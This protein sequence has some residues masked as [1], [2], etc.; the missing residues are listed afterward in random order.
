MGV[1]YWGPGPVGPKGPTGATGPEGPTGATGPEG[2]TGATGPTGPTGPEGPAG[3][4]GPTGATGPPGTTLYSGL[5]GRPFIVITPD[6]PTDGGDYGPNT[7]GTKTFGLYEALSSLT[8]GGTI[9]IADGTYSWD[10]TDASGQPFIAYPHTIIV[11]GSGVVVNY[12]SGTQAT[13][14]NIGSDGS[15]NAYTLN[16]IYIYGNGAVINSSSSGSSGRIFNL[17]NATPTGQTNILIDGFEID[18]GPSNPFGISNGVTN[19]TDIT[20]IIHNLS[21]GNIYSHGATPDASDKWQPTFFISQC[22]NVHLYNLLLDYTDASGSP[23]D[24]GG[25]YITSNGGQVVNVLI[26][27]LTLLSN[28]VGQSIELQGC[29]NSAQTTQLVTTNIIIQNFYFKSLT[30]GAVGGSGG[31]Y[32]DDNNN[33]TSSNFGVI[34]NVTFRNGLWNNVGVS[35]QSAT[36]YFGYIQFSN[37][38]P[39]VI[40]GSLSG[41]TPGQTVGISV[42]ASPFVYTNND[43]FNEYV[44]ISGG[45]VSQI[46]IDG[47]A[48]DLSSVL[49][50]LAP[51]HTITVEYSATPT[52]TK[53]GCGL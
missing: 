14:L 30:N 31:V 18:F 29:S 4:T 12:S 13:L 44:V 16:N 34:T 28:S 23:Q 33:D 46:N 20:S 51:G 42:G 22:V 37:S 47:L 32:M 48:V 2:P 24:A 11:F 52:M 45:T 53:A 36:T 6:G 15:G 8:T 10:L 43:A 25:I 3:P 49:V 39:N 40:S 19:W 9:Y 41:R 35:F 26:D 21:I 5:S 50:Y 7:S 38:K 1:F 27:N 17:G